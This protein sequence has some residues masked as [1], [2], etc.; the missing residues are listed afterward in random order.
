MTLGILATAVFLTA[1][2]YVAASLALF[3]GLV[4]LLSRQAHY[5]EN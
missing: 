3:L 4:R 5:E 1:G 2:S